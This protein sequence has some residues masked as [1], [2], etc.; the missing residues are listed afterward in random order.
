FYSA[1]NDA[2]RLAAQF[3]AA[4]LSTGAYVYTV[5]V[6][7]WWGTEYRESTRLVRVLVVNERS[8][9]YG[10]GWGVAGL[11]RL[12]AQ[13]S[14]VVMTGGD[15]SAAFF[16]R[17]AC[18]TDA[19]DSRVTC[20]FAS[21]TGDFSVLRY[22]ST[23]AKYTRRHLDGTLVVFDGAGRLLSGTDRFG[24]G[25][26]YDYDPAG[27]LWRITDA[28]GKQTTLAYTAAGKIASIQDPGG[29][30]S[31]FAVDAAGNLVRA[32]DPDGVAALRVAYDT[33]H[34]LGTVWNRGGYGTTVEYDR[35]GTVAATTL[36]GVTAQ[37]TVVRPVLRFRS[38]AATILPD[39]GRGGFAQPA[40]RMLPGEVW[41]RVTEPR[42]DSA[43]FVLDRWGAV[44]R[45]RDA[46]GREDRV[47]R[48]ALGQDTL[49][50]SSRGDTVHYSWVGPEL[51]RTYRNGW[52]TSPTGRTVRA[53]VWSVN[54][55]YEQTFHQPVHVSG[56][57]TEAWYYYGALGRMDSTKT[58]YINAPR[59]KF[60]YDAR[61]RLL[62]A[63]DPE[64][65]ETR[66]F[67]DGNPWMNTDSAV[68][69]G[70]RRVAMAYDGFGRDTLSRDPLDRATRTEYDAVNRALRTIGPRQDTTSFVYDRLFLTGVRDAVGQRYGSEMNA[71]GWDTAQVSPRGLRD[72]TTYDASG[73]VRG[74]TNR[75]GQTISFAYDA[76]NRVTERAAGADT[77]RYAYDPDERWVEVRNAES[78]DT[79]YADTLGRVT[80][81][82]SVRAGQPH[83]ITYAYPGAD[84]LLNSV[85]YDPPGTVG[86]TVGP[87]YA[88]NSS[89]QLAE[90]NFGGTTTEF[91]Y[92]TRRMLSAIRFPT[93]D[94]L[95]VTHTS[96]GQVA[97][98]SHSNDALE[99]AFGR[100]YGY[101]RLGR[102][103]T[104]RTA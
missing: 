13:P 86:I 12:H 27:R 96:Q 5:V 35:V 15:G 32:T 82:T 81:S 42:G 69:P 37:G 7:S 84:A 31:R 70:A 73:N 43:T 85:S 52:K 99:R 80:R 67:R 63:R 30:V 77:T 61:G 93:G 16:Q 64:G 4:T 11:L 71:L 92:D 48:N 45:A 26:G 24:N 104:R 68:S 40:P 91:D 54:V 103:T 88:Y 57:V 98:V 66:I 53:P 28:A 22:D 75:R 14:G 44:T 94:T 9:P 25:S 21:P 6:R 100:H 47:L 83:V 29:R 59:S 76:R 97:R 79:V 10:A 51:R 60:T 23:E 95:R 34:R 56:N 78:I 74:Y 17:G 46:R 1:G 87:R 8:S 38:P 58:G 49:A 2:T 39:S 102:I 89:R 62:T 3:D 20:D 55:E 18:A 33:R 90:I 101:D 41:A 65:Y 19:N 36:P 72:R 50:I